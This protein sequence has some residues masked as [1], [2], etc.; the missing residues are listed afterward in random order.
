MKTPVVDVGE[1]NPI[2]MTGAGATTSTRNSVG[3][4]NLKTFKGSINGLQFERALR[5][6]AAARGKTQCVRKWKTKGSCTGTPGEANGRIIAANAEWNDLTD[7]QMNARYGTGWDNFENWVVE[8]VE[9]H[10]EANQNC[11]TRDNTPTD[12]R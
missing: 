7:A 12:A 3:T 1:G 8:K 5:V 2:I 11:K 4:F 10:V 6:A 9:F